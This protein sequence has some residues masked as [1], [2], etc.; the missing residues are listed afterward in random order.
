MQRDSGGQLPILFSYLCLYLFLAL[1][2]SNFVSHWAHS[3][4]CGPIRSQTFRDIAKQPSFTNLEVEQDR[5]KAKLGR[6]QGELVF[7]KSLLA[8]GEAA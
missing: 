8:E 2:L 6:V 5:L 7:L 3:S 1:I 4:L